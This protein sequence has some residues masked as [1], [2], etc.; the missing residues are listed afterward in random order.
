MVDISERLCT[1][2]QAFELKQLGLIQTSQY[3]WEPD[4]ESG[5]AYILYDHLEGADIPQVIDWFKDERDCAAAF[6][7]TDLG[8]F[9]K[10]LG[11]YLSG[12]SYVPPGL[13]D[14]PNSRFW[15]DDIASVTNFEMDTYKAYGS[16]EAEAK[17]A[18]LIWLIKNGKVPAIWEYYRKDRIEKMARKM[19]KYGTKPNTD[20][21]S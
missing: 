5:E 15:A 21:D 6:D 14:D 12:P 11:F 1:P 9:F 17:A 3:A 13:P 20:L 18:L 4:A 19:K 16:T 2:A 7:L 10:S 8:I